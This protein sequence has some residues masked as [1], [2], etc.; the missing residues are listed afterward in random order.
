M[1]AQNNVS[2][3]FGV[4]SRNNKKTR[5]FCETKHIPIISRTGLFEFPVIKI[6]YG[7]YLNHL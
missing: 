2:D 1:T 5:N 6:Q 3:I 7:L 4:F